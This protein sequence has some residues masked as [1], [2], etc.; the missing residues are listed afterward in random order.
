MKVIYKIL[1]IITIHVFLV[2]VLVLLVL[3]HQ[4]IV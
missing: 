4:E 2:K 3:I 1:L